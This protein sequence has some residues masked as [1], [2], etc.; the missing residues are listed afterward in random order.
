MDSPA[1]PVTPRLRLR[2]FRETDLDA[3]AAITAD[4]ETMRYLGDGRALS[5]DDASRSL[6]YMRAHWELRGYGLWAAE[7]RSSG[8]LVGRIGLYRPQGWPGLEV[9]WLIERSRW[10]EGLATEGA[11]AVV[12]WAFERRLSECLISVI[13]PANRASVRVAEK[14]GERLREH[15]Q[16]AGLRVAIYAL[17]REAWLSSRDAQARG[18]PEMASERHDLDERAAVAPRHRS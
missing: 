16:L 9:G 11:R 1:E 8:E 18:V 5:R 7:E 17:E 12:S 10:G 4:A 14:L 2:R 6:A 15:R 13:Q 3:W